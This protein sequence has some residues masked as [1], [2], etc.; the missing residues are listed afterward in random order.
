MNFKYFQDLWWAGEASLVLQKSL[1][2]NS[3]MYNPIVLLTLLY[4]AEISSV[5]KVDTQRLCL[6]DV[7]LVQVVTAYSK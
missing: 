5:Y 1:C 3:V 6:Y 7:S 4:I 2:K